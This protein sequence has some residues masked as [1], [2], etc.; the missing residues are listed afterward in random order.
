MTAIYRFGRFE[1]SP[2]TRQL[3]VD[4]QPAPLGARAF[5]VLLALI[6]R[7][8]RLVTKNELFD[9]V[10]PGSVVEENNLTVQ[11]SALRK[12]LGADAIATVPGFGYRFALETE[13]DVAETPTPA[14]MPTNNLPQQI[15]SFVGRERERDD[16]KQ[17]LAEHRL[18]TLV[19]IGGIGKTR[20]SL[21]VAADVL[22]AFPDGVWLVEVGSISDPS[23]VPM[24]VAQV[25]GVGERA[26]TD[27]THTLCAYLKS[28]RLLLVLDNCEH[29]IEAC[30]R[31]TDSLLTAA[32]E[33]R[34]LATSREP[35]QLRGEQNVR[36]Q[37]LSLPDRNADLEDLARAEAVQLFVERIR[38]KQPRF[39]VSESQAQAVAQICVR[40]DGIP[41][42][43]ELAAARVATLSIEEIN[44]RLIDQF[45]LLTGTGRGAPP[46]HQTLRA[47][48]DWSY[49]MLAEQERMVL[50][51]L[52][53]FPSDF[54]LNSAASIVSDDSIDEDGVVDLVSQLVTRSLVAVNTE[55]AVTRYRLLETTRAYAFAKLG[56]VGETAAIK[57]RHAQ[58]F[59]EMLQRAPLDWLELPDTDWNT[60]YPPERDNVRA[61]LRW[62]L[63]ESGDAAIGIALASAAGVL[64]LGFR[65]RHWLETAIMKV[66]PNTPVTDQARLWLWRGAALS[67]TAPA[68]AVAA[69]EQA[70]VLYRRLDDASGLGFA[71]SRL[72]KT[73]TVMGRLKQAEPV[74]E[75]ALPL[76]QRA[77][78]PKPLAY[79]FEG[80]GILKM[81]T[82]D[83]NN[84]RM[85][86]EKAL[87]LYGRAG[88]ETHL[89][90]VRGVLAESTWALG[91][92]DAALGAFR[93]VIAKI[94][95]S[96]THFPNRSFGIYLL[97]LA[98][99]H[100]E[101]GELDEALVHVREGMQVLK[102]EGCAW[103]VL[104]HVALRAAA[105]GKFVN[106]TRIAGFA[107][108]ANVANG[109]SRQP[110]QARARTRLQLLL[111]EKLAPDELE[112]LL[113]EGANLVEDDVYRMALEG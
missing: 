36:L 38:L 99:V 91:D 53:I 35:M 13:H 77:D 95:V 87:S 25:L 26:G 37:P 68:T 23:L 51:R 111:S 41:L 21:R 66:A 39:L 31:L 12:L 62:A 112:R 9:L 81:F 54:A 28:R 17:L 63:S 101:R 3:L 11:V 30:A 34:V 88:A 89:L 97:N 103:Q 49:G 60:R 104:D 2:A 73:L 52:A 43:L 14:M 98:G 6:E 7:R 72:G 92:L 15:T 32:A 46:R 61:A 70:I 5:D 40:L 69:Y 96:S 19:G 50:R 55:G 44:A 58:H 84:A 64:L 113:A 74:L 59:C 79:V 20:L 83:I 90:N 16:V 67:I 8:D 45:K 107:D 109:T 94:R 18:V 85:H 71:L 33:I 86:L 106:A 82:G 80:L 47:T 27:L 75:E 110:N 57:A 105:V 76:L 10:W 42:A 100:I 65:D 29:L 102:D 4:H 56:E 48:L 24:S 22:D 1:L 78:Q 108:A 93:E